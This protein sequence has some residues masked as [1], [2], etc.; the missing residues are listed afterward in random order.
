MW[1]F[2]RGY[3]SGNPIFHPS[4]RLSGTAG[5]TGPGG[6]G[7][8]GAWGP[9]GGVFYKRPRHGKISS[10]LIS[11]EFIAGQNHGTMED[12]NFCYAWLEGLE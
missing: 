9:C 1:L 6:G 3:P 7:R 10:K 11:M 8:T 4:F 5:A 12:F 2:T